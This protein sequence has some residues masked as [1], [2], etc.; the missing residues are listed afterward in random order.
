MPGFNGTII[1]VCYEDVQI[2]CDF[3][4]VI[5]HDF[6]IC[7]G[8]THYYVSD[9]TYEEL[10]ALDVEDSLPAAIK[11]VLNPFWDPVDKKCQRCSP[12]IPPPTF[13]KQ[14]APPLLYYLLNAAF[15]RSF[16]IE[17]KY[18]AK[19]EVDHFALKLPIPIERY[20]EIIQKTLDTCNLT[21]S[22]I[23]ISSFYPEVCVWF[24]QHTDYAVHFLTEA[25]WVSPDDARLNSLQAALD[26]ALENKLMG[27][28]SNTAGILLPKNRLIVKSIKDAGLR[29]WTYG[30]E[31]NDS[32]LVDQ[33]L[34]LGVVGIITDDLKQIRTENYQTNR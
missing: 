8:D 11:G 4:P 10:V 19:Y 7:K 5:F 2:S 1:F 12:N 32:K 29:L 26:F 6:L 9:L 30:K 3:Q 15:P 17:I 31:N 16:N 14:D 27:I 22:D 23:V 20:C 13:R 21:K 33:Q 18:P 24:R 25:S 34:D 28:V